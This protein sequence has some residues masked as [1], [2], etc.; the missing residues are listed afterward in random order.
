MTKRKPNVLFVFPDQW[1]KQAIGFLGEDPVMTPNV[2]RFARE[3]MFLDNAISCFPLCSPN[4]SSMLTGRYPLSTGVTTNCKL[5]LNVAMKANEKTIGNMLKDAGY[6]T[7][8][9]GKWHLDEPEQNREQKP[10]SGAAHWDAYIP[11]GDRRFGFDF[12]YAYNAYDRHLSPHYWKDSPEM[13]EVDEWSLQHETD[14]AADFIRG[15]DKEKP[16][17]LFLSWN[18]PHQPFDEVPDK[19]KAMYADM[20]IDFRPNMLE[21]EAKQ[22]AVDHL[23]DY[24]AAVTGMD[25]QF[26]R[27]LELLREEGIEDETIVVLTSDHGE[28]MGAH[29]WAEHKNIWYE[30]AI[31]V[32]CMFRWPGAIKNGG[33]DVLFNSVDLVPTLLGLIGLEVPSRVQGTDLSTVMLEGEAP[34]AR[35]KSAF[36]CHYPG[37]LPEHAEAARTGQDINAYGWRGVRTASHT[38]VAQKAFGSNVPERLLFDNITDPFQLSPKRIADPKEDEM[39]EELEKEL[40]QWLERIGDPFSLNGA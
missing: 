36:I 40:Q 15:R 20:E 5:G 17:A 26:G 1:R 34:S 24:Y 39:A 7:G 29:N 38:Y 32:P 8:Y 16:F 11:P 10:L 33:S 19:Y 31:V 37:A 12:W 27:L 2:D 6:A 3:S 25:E 18:P 23:R 13:I 4:R 28:L 30:E 14:V 22:Q 21:G 35:P 9:I